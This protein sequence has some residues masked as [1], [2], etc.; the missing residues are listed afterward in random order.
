V[1]HPDPDDLLAFAGGEIT[2]ER[3]AAI[4][5][6]I[7]GC[8]TCADLVV[9]LARA[10]GE[11]GE[12]GATLDA[13]LAAGTSQKDALA[14][15]GKLERFHVLDEVGRGAM[16]VVYAAYDPD[17][18]RRVA[19]KVLRRRAA[20]DHD[21]DLRFLREAQAMA[22]LAHPNVITVHE[23]RMVDGRLY[24]SMEFVEGGTLTRW[25]RREDRSWSE[26]LAVFVQIARGLAAAHTAGLVH[27]DIKPDNVLV[28]TDQRV[29]VTDFGLA[30]P[31]ESALDE[32]SASTSA[33]TQAALSAELTRTGTL[34]GTP[35]YM[36]PEQLRGEPA[37]A[38]SDQFAYCVAFHEALF[39]VRPF[40]GERVADL[41]ANVLADRR[42]DPSPDRNVPRWL[43]AVLS[44]GL[45]SDPAARHPSMDA[46]LA[47]LERGDR[48]PQRR[49]QLGAVVAALAVGGVSTLAVG[50]VVSPACSGIEQRRRL[51]VCDEA[52]AEL[53]AAWNDAVRADV[54]AAFRATGVGYA[55]ATAD[56]FVAELDAF[57]EEWT[58]V[59]RTSCAAAVEHAS[60]LFFDAATTECLYDRRAE[61]EAL[62]DSVRLSDPDL[63]PEAVPAAAMMSRPSS[64]ADAVWLAR[65]ADFASDEPA[66]R[67]LR[68]RLRRADAMHAAGR[69]AESLAL[70]REVE[71]EATALGHA[72]LRISATWRIGLLQQS[73]SDHET[74]ARTLESAFHAAWEG[75][76]DLLAAD[77]ARTLVLL[78]AERGRDDEG[79]R[80]AA[81]AKSTYDRAQE[82]GDSLPRAWLAMA[83][84]SVHESLGEFDTA[85]ADLRFAL[86]IA[87]HRFGPDHVVVGRTLGNL[88]VVLARAGEV[89][90]AERVLVRVL[91][92]YEAALGPEHP[93]TATIL[94]NLG[95]AVLAQGEYERARTCFERALAVRERVFGPDHADVAD[96]LTNLGNVYLHL[97]RPKDALAAQE[98]A[99]RI[100][101]RLHGADHPRVATSMA[102]IASVHYHLG[103]LEG[104]TDDYRRALAILQRTAGPHDLVVA[105]IGANLG[106]VLFTRGLFAEAL[107]EFEAALATFDAVAPDH[108]DLVFTLLGLGDTLLVLHRPAEAVPF[109]ERLLVHDQRD[110][111]GE[112]DLEGA[113]RSLAR[114][115]AAAGSRADARRP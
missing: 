31:L 6:H 54:R 53:D 56:R 27:R 91:A 66:V 36:A 9:A 25:L 101:I 24:I 79:L 99:Q 75:G 73:A 51:A 88:G 5:E 68:G 71:T 32:A 76:E 20:P 41:V 43:R 82:P 3:R 30:R 28:G 86:E 2:S 57:A 42:V 115:R 78:S 55:D 40:T 47:E 96:V 26:V 46:L 85:R 100:V 114:A 33:P 72:T 12:P 59:R 70:A 10:Y 34:L 102:A 17:L 109:F 77:I 67:A 44:R 13:T 110:R 83:L 21:A 103:D 80:W 18:D 37:D 74:A 39:G 111:L 108:P 11:S 81:I 38:A 45:A 113:R 69:H 62:V 61:L 107:A 50:S 65:H 14:P 90:E 89:E 63:V 104:S 95:G 98:R 29:R 15:G 16:G 19:L 1:E 64:C 22:R 4:D 106:N 93:S 52:A 7:D 92:L 60:A 105:V 112:A 94:N 35:A 48:T 58:D 97:E 87:E 23:A 84:A 8:S 49:R